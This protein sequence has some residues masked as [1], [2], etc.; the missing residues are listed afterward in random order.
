V[1]LDSVMRPLI[2]SKYKATVRIERLTKKG[3]WKDVGWLSFAIMPSKEPGM[4]CQLEWRHDATKDGRYRALEDGRVVDT[5]WW[6][7]HDSV[8]VN[9]H[10]SL[11][12][13]KQISVT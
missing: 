10:G 4:L 11:T 6:A 13:A 12:V 2:E 1:N 5:G 9:R 3:T 7:G 8:Y